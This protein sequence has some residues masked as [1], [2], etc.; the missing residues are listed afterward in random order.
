M[1]N[2]G[3]RLNGG[4]VIVRALQRFGVRTAFSL[5]G[6]AHTHVLFAMEDAKFRIVSGRHETGTVAAADGY[7]RVSGRLGV[8]LIKADQGLPNALTAIMTAQLACSPVLVLASLTP[9]NTL[10]AEGED[11]NDILDLIKAHTKWARTV[12][13]PER[14]A[15]YVEAGARQ[16]LSGRPGVAVLGIPQNFEAAAVEYAERAREAARPVPPAPDPTA[17]AAAAARIARAKRPLILAGTGAALADSGEALRRLATEFRLPVLGNALGRGLVPEDD[18]LGFS[19]P[20][21]QVAA[22]EADLVLAV[23]LRLTQ[24]F[25]Y[26][27]APRFAPDATFIQVDIHPP[28]MGR[29]RP[30]DVAITADARLATEALHEALAR[31]GYRAGGDP[32][33]VNDALATR[34]ARI[35]ELGRDDAAPIHPYRVARDLMA[36]MPADAIYVG[37][38]ADIQNWMHGI[39]RIRHPRGFMDHYPLGSMGIGTPLALGAA[40]AARDIAEETGTPERPVVLV[41]GDGSFGFYCAEFNG[42][43][44]AGLKII[45]VIS[46][47]G[48]WGTEKHG[49]MNALGRTVN[50]VLGQADYHLIAEAFGCRGERIEEPA[51]LLPAL[52]RAFAAEGSTV[53][54]VITDPAAGIVRKQ[55]PRVQTVAFDDL[56]TNMKKHYT[57]AVA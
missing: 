39:L 12:P 30:V 55:D 26:G 16:A 7:A 1:M 20:L 17:I 28:A 40:A 6:T 56:V 57:P 3:N 47:D 38:G 14:L 8:A 36:C 19:W 54:N 41:T 37:D 53:L 4:Q 33:W 9:A 49:Q 45:C 51:A 34:N 52:R 11:D 29:N 35:A 44:L 22:K 25:G 43:A 10:E 18:R 13:D 31:T 48:A 2:A 5:A 27:L 23:G 46:N 15:E 21:A 24:R 50:C 32:T 42:A